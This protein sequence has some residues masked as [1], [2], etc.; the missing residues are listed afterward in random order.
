MRLKQKIKF[1]KGNAETLV[2]KEQINIKRKKK[3]DLKDK[4]EDRK[5]AK[6]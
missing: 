2:W 6:I 3:K 4:E 1:K 5:E